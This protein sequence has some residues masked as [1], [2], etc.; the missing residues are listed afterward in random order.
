MTS[1]LIAIIYLTFISLG[2]PDGLLGSAWPVMHADLGAPVAAQSAI[3]ITISCGTIIS[4]LMTA[5][6]VRKLGTELLSA[7]SVACTAATILGFSAASSL[8]QLCLIAI[9]YGLGAGAI[10]S[11]LNNYVA[12]HFGARHM[13]WLHCCWGVGAS[14]GPIVMGWALTGSTSWHGG[15]L[16]IGG[17]QAAITALLFFTLPLWK[18]GGAAEE[19]AKQALADDEHNSGATDEASAPLTNRQL[20]KL[21]G[22]LAAVG[23]FGCY[24]A[25]ESSTGLWVASYLVMVRGIDA[26]TAASIVSLFFIGI[27]VGRLLSGFAAGVLGSV[28]QIRLG[29]AC[30]AAGIVLLLL[31]PVT[32][33]IW[34]AVGLIGLG[35]APIYPSIVALTPHRFGAH[36]SQGLVSLQMAFAYTGTSLVPPVFG[37]IAGAGGAMFIPFMLF[38]LLVANTVL[39]ERATAKAMG[40][41]SYR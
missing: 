25:L 5:R 11:A 31:A 13:S 36:A 20:L 15:Y 19:L 34:L 38:A 41:Q 29:Q 8:W 32:A 35:C 30:V 4:S 22:A 17:M 40:R 27:T 33:V 24:C 1:L 39:S 23:S 10:D 28:Q 37:L 6:L 9:P 14:V 12:L 18:R 16:I 21:P 2:L 3:S 7:I 26:A